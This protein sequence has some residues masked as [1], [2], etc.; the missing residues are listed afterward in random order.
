MAFFARCALTVLLLAAPLAAQRFALFLQGGGEIIVREYEVLDDRVRYYSL[1]RSDWEE[2][3]LELVDLDKTRAAVERQEKRL[4]SM[5]AETARERAA[6]RKARTELHYVPVD[7]GV[8]FFLDNVATP[9][10][11]S[12]VLTEKSAKRGI[13]KVISPI[14]VVA[15]KNTLA[16]DG[17]QARFVTSEARPVFFVRQTQLSH[18]GIVKLEPKK[19]QRIVQIVQVHP[20]TKEL[21]EEQT[22]V[23]V[24]R[25]QLASGVYRVW[26]VE[27]LEPGEYAVTDFTPGALDLRVWDFSYRPDGSSD[28]SAAPAATPR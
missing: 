2:I 14:P 1:E 5:K 26:P 20:Q 18:F 11:Q 3:P 9:I 10:E 7:D 21:F 13:L 6:E 27:D 19:D 22:D 25:Q 16:L 17:L 4:A 15:G 28:G 8:Y 24:F 23:Q 12:E